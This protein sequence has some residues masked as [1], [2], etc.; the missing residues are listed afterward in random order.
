MQTLHNNLILKITKIKIK[1]LTQSKLSKKYPKVI[2]RSE[3]ECLLP[4]LVTDSW[5]VLTALPV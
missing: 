1:N 4:L 3:R 5:Y 2:E